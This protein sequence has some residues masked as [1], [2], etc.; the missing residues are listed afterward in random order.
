MLHQPD[1]PRPHHYQFAHRLLTA[2][3]LRGTRLNR[4]IRRLTDV[5]GIF[6]GRDSVIRLDGA[7]RPTALLYSTAVRIARL[8][9]G[10]DRLHAPCRQ[11]SRCWASAHVRSQ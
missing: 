6:P 7:A 4:E 2:L 11:F 9:R 8:G 5:V 10:S 3:V 1:R